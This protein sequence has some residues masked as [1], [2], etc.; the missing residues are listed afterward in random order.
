MSLSFHTRFTLPLTRFG[1]RFF[2]VW[3]EYFFAEKNKRPP[4][5][6]HM[7]GAHVNTN[8]GAATNIQKLSASM[9]TTR[10]SSR[11]AHVPSDEAWSQPSRPPGCDE[12]D[13][14]A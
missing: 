4:P 11:R 10:D 2:H 3:E 13:P 6:P 14:L 9:R 8:E 7:G 12:G 1:A 5:P